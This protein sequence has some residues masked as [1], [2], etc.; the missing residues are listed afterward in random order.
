MK[1]LYLLISSILYVLSFSPFDYK[2]SIFF[3]LILLF[4]VLDGLSVRDKV[5]SILYFSVAFHLIGVSWISHSLINFGSLGYL[6]SYAT[7]FIV[8]LIISLPYALV[9]LHQSASKNG[10]LNLFFIASLFVVAEYLK[11]FMFG[12]FPWLLIGHSQN[13]TVFDYVYPFFGS[14][15]VSYLVVLVSLFFYIAIVHSKKLYILLSI[16]SLL[17]IPL[18]THKNHNLFDESKTNYL[19]FILYQ[20]NSYPNDSYDRSKHFALMEKYNN[21]LIKN[22]SS[23]LVIFPETIISEPYDK[24]NKLYKYFQSSK[25]KDNLLISGLFSSKKNHYYNSM[26]F[27]SDV[28]QTYNKRKLVPFGE[29]TPWYNSLLKLSENLKIPLSNLSHGSN[30]IDKISF[31]NINLIPM[32]CFESTFPHLIESSADNEIIINISNDGWFG[33]TLAPYQ[34]LQ[35]TQ[36]RALEFNRYILRATNTGISAVINNQGQVVDMLEN[37]VE[38]TLKGQIPT[39]MRRSFYSEYGDLS[40]LML[41][42]FSLLIKGINI[43][44]KY[45]E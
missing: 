42:F 8:A 9:G 41:I 23:D 26:I 29:Y 16:V 22:K 37:N 43:V 40:V 21:I 19:S 5:K 3:S 15:T 32:I 25:N 35:I 24:N 36:I 14:L 4:H 27:F 10:L 45:H 18:I 6:L 31:G 39:T 34:H 17:L 12:G 13:S 20:P 38:G 28:T 44:T 11:S 1:L 2:L 30:E 7:T 33:N